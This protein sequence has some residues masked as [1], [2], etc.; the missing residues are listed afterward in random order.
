MLAFH[1]Q[2]NTPLGGLGGEKPII[3]PAWILSLDIEYK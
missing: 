1:V 2:S 3:E